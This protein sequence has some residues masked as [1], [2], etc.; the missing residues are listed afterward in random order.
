[1]KPWQTVVTSAFAVTTAAF[2]LACGPDAPPDT[3]PDLFRLAVSGLAGGSLLSVY[4][5]H[6]T[7]RAYLAGGFVGVDPARLDGQSPGR[8]VVYRNP[9]TF[10]TVCTADAVLWWTAPV[11]GVPWAAGERGRVLRYREGVGCEAVATGLTF[12]EGDPTYWGFTQVGNLTWFVGG[13]ARPDGP[14]GVLVRYD[15][16]TFTRVEVPPEARDVNL[17]KVAARANGQLVV[18]GE[19]GV[20]FRVVDGVATAPDAT[21]LT[22]SDRRLFTVSCNGDACWAVG[23]QNTGVVLYN[24]TGPGTAWQPRAFNEAAGWNGVWF[25]DAS[26][27]FIVGVNGQTMHTDGVRSFMARALTP[28]TLHGVGGWVRPDG[29]STVALAVGGELDT[30]DAT[31][32]AVILVRGDDS[33]GFTVDGRAFVPSGELRRSLGG[34]GQ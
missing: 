28:A 2:A 7:A 15:G 3:N 18:V 22:G 13:S 31:Q 30:A 32:R 10:T 24:D 12:P 25:A 1:M 4:G 11:D 27:T 26:N 16:A 34:T 6:R 17:Y 20:V 9:G 19:R 14:K 5:D 21:T 29:T 8:L 33:A 23:G